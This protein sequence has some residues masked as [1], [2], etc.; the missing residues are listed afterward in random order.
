MG[1]LFRYN[2]PMYERNMLQYLFTDFL[3]IWSPIRRSIARKKDFARSTNV[4]RK[5]LT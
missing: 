1:V 2:A 5:I 4:K 3:H